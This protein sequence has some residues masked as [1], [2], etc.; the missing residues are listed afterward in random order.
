MFA[1]PAMGVLADGNSSGRSHSCRS[2]GWPREEAQSAKQTWVN[3]SREG[4]LS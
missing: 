1:Q 2:K 4:F 3:A